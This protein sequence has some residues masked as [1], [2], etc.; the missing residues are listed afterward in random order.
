MEIHVIEDCSTDNTKAVIEK[1][2]SDFPNR[3][4]THYNSENKGVIRNMNE[5]VDSIDSEYIFRLDSD[6]LIFRTT[7]EDLVEV[8]DHS[9]VG[10]VYPLFRL[11]GDVNV[12]FH[13]REYDLASLKLNNYIPSFSL[14]R[15]EAWLAAGKYKQE[16]SVGYED[17][18][19]WL[20]MAEAGWYGKLLP[21]LR[22]LYRRHGDSKDARAHLKYREVAE[23]L[24]QFHPDLYKEMTVES[25]CKAGGYES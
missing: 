8:M 17:W 10:V 20:S 19:M 13:A 2:V 7:V 23:L 21:K 4:V 11:F 25:I 1:V 18:D 22:C 14:C 12:D 15:R 9:R 5:V 16:F 24:K 6:D 3:I